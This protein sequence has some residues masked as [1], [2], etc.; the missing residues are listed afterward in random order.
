LATGDRLSAITAD[1]AA[2]FDVVTRITP[3]SD[4]R[5]RTRVGTDAGELD[6]QTYFV[7]RRHTD[8]VTGIRFDGIETARPAPGVIETIRT[9]DA[10]VIAPSNPVLSIWPILGVEGV[11]A[12]IAEVGRVVAVS[13]LIRGQAV[14]GPAVEVMRGLGLPA[15]S[16]GVLDAYRGLVTHLVI[17]DAD[18]APIPPG[19]NVLRTNTMIAEPNAGA[20][21][22]LEIMDWLT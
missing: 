21:L 6:F 14:K 20:R 12:A 7:R 3:V 13:P 4:D 8:R 15:D 1:I 16:S 18:D 11:E 10:V 17:D 19:V 9:S 2:G 5:I 22:A